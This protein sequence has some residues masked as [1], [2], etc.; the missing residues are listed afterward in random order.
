MLKTVV[1]LQ[2]VVVGS[3]SVLLA[4]TSQPTARAQLTASV[5]I[6]SQPAAPASTPTDVPQ[7]PPT[8]TFTGTFRG[9][10]LDDKTSDAIAKFR[11]IQADPD[12][13][14]ADALA[15]ALKALKELQSK[16]DCTFA[17]Q[18]KEVDRNYDPKIH[19]EAS[20]GGDA[21]IRRIPPPACLK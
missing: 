9:F 21:K 5:V 11:A 2:T 20:Q 3:V 8:E 12:A 1:V 6:P 15:N 16:I 18:M 13:A 4:L 7:L 14:K 19:V 17:L 10:K